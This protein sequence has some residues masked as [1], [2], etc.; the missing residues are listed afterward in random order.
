MILG[1][2]RKRQRQNNVTMV[3]ISVRLYVFHARLETVVVKFVMFFAN[4][5]K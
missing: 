2:E 3:T 5:R 4:A 1:R